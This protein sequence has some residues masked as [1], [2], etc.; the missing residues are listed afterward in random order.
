MSLQLIYHEFKLL[1]NKNGEYEGFFLQKMSSFHVLGFDCCYTPNLQT[2]S[3]ETHKNVTF[4]L[5]WHNKIRWLILARDQNLNIFKLKIFVNMNFEKKYFDLT[6]FCLKIEN[7]KHKK[8][9]LSLSTVER[10]E[11]GQPQ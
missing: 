7:F 4:I 11:E 8:E 2:N 5:S 10:G 9:N 6:K 1:N 3:L